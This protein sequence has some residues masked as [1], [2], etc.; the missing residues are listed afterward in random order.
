MKVR[1][2]QVTNFKSYAGTQELGPFSNFTAIIGTNASGKSN[3]FDAICFVLGAQSSALRCRDLNDLIY[4]G[5]GERQT[6]ASVQLTLENENLKQKTFRR[7]IKDAGCMYYVDGTKCAATQY[8]S[9]L[10]NVGFHSIFQSYIIFQGEI[11]TMATM[12][13]KDLTCM[14]EKLS[15]S[16]EYKESYETSEKQL[17]EISKQ[18]KDAFQQESELGDRYREL[19]AAAAET[20]KFKELNEAKKNTEEKVTLFILYQNSLQC[21]K[22]R[23]DISALESQ[24]QTL[25]D[26]AKSQQEVANDMNNIIKTTKGILKNAEKA[27]KEVSQE[28]ER[29]LLMKTIAN[30]KRFDAETKQINLKR[31]VAQLNQTKKNENEEKKNLNA[32]IQKFAK[33]ND[34][35]IKQR[36]AIRSIVNSVNNASISPEMMVKKQEYEKAKLELKMSESNLKRA[37]MQLNTIEVAVSKIGDEPVI[38]EIIE[39]IGSQEDKIKEINQKIA[40]KQELYDYSKIKYRANDRIKQQNEMLQKLQNTIQ[41]VHGFVRDIFRPIRAKYEQ[42][43]AS[44]IGYHCDEIIVDSFETACQCIAFLKQFNLGKATFIPLDITSKKHDAVKEGTLAPLSDFIE[45]DQQYKPIINYCCGDVYLCEEDSEIDAAWKSKKYKKVINLQGTIYKSSGCLTGGKTR[46]SAGLRIDPAKI[47]AEI[48]SLNEELKKIRDF[49]AESAKKH[50]KSVEA[51]NSAI[52]EKNLYIEKKKRLQDELEKRKEELNLVQQEFNKAKEACSIAKEATEIMNENESKLHAELLQKLQDENKDLLES[53]NVENIEKLI[54]LDDQ[55]SEKEL[56]IAEDKSKLAYLEQSS[57][58]ERINEK[59]N[60]LSVCSNNFKSFTNEVKEI[61]QKI[62]ELRKSLSEAQKNIDAA[63]S[64]VTKSINKKKELIDKS[65]GSMREA[66]Q[67]EIKIQKYERNFHQ[68]KSNIENVLPKSQFS[69]FEDVLEADFSD[70]PDELLPSCSPSECESK[71]KKMRKSIVGYEE[72]MSKITPNFKAA[73]EAIVMKE[74]KKQSKELSMNLRKQ[75]KKILSEFQDVRR[76]RRDIFQQA[77]AKVRQEASYVYG[78]LT[79]T[80]TQ[81]L[82]GTAFLSPDREDTPFIGGTLYSVI[83]PHKKERTL[84]ILSGGEQTLAIVALAF[85]L[86]SIRPSPI[87]V[88]DEIDSALDAKNVSQLSEFLSSQ[89]LAKQLLIISHKPSVFSQAETLIGIARREGCKSQ[90]FRFVLKETGNDESD[91]EP[92]LRIA[93]SD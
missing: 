8:K 59:N 37:T 72:E 5:P 83:P 57:I 41:G 85:A 80:K 13:P 48:R 55:F 4:K 71:L 76:K 78:K 40:R 52:A 23:E 30:A 60:E 26:S 15:G 25:K 16:I 75:Q 63:R 18:T 56:E 1:S 74:K 49:E 10:C 51:H 64:D 47:E 89:T 39:P 66:N 36:A 46:N 92:M 31:E 54:E 77:L 24:A 7:T 19:K 82:G 21:K 28:M 45:C 3:C 73:D 70:L 14:L 86:N 29:L 33:E 22:I 68:A 2:L 87:F 6:M 79:S 53:L 34:D 44:G 11:G 93:G 20:N 81:P 67:I 91:E 58:Q 43:I 69:S 88:L 27:E 84:D 42:A 90:A 17:N 62:N 61:E 9:S 50:Q 38:P 65:K 35:I 12:K 32:K